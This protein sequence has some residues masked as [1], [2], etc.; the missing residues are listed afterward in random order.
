MPDKAITLTAGKNATA[1]QGGVTLKKPRV[2]AE[3]CIGC[4]ICEY[5][6]PVSG[7]SAIVIERRGA[8]LARPGAGALG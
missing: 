8:G 5:R 4:G 3:R 1:G 6:C 7:R 2:V